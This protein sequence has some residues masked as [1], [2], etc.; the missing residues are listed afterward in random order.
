VSNHEFDME[1]SHRRLMELMVSRTLKKHG[2]KSGKSNL[3]DNEKEKLKSTIQF[4]QKQSSELLGKSNT[5]TEDDVNQ[6]TKMYEGEETE[7][8]DATGSESYSKVNS[9][10][11][12]RRKNR[13]ID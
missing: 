2:I 3:S 4:L 13:R 11:R 8:N 9:A 5:I 7:S 10:K 12:K 1:E 6:T